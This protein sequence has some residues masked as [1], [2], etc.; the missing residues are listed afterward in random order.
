[1]TFSVGTSGNSQHDG[2][3]IN[4]TSDPIGIV[5]TDEQPFS[6]YL[7]TSANISGNTYMNQYTCPGAN[8]AKHTP[9]FAMSVYN[10]ISGEVHTYN[11]VTG[12]PVCPSCNAFAGI[13]DYMPVLPG[14]TVSVT[15]TGKV[16]CTL[17]GAFFALTESTDQA[18][19]KE[20]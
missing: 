16:K 19:K 17:A 15:R 5:D 7:H 2:V 11:E 6:I 14:D 4:V 1:M 20:V 10:E 8:N 13:D 3:T 12:Q 18:G 9:S